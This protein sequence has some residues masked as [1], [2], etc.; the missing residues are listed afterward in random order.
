MTSSVLNM[1]VAEN[2]VWLRPNN[3]LERRL[4]ERLAVEPLLS[5]VQSSEVIE[6]ASKYFEK[7]LIESNASGIVMPFDT[8]DTCSLLYQVQE[9]VQFLS[10]YV[11][12][13]KLLKRCVQKVYVAC[14]D[15]LEEE[16]EFYDEEFPSKKSNRCHKLADSL[17]STSSGF[18]DF[19]GFLNLLLLILTITMLGSATGNIVKYGVLISPSQVVNMVLDPHQWPCLKLFFCLGV[20]PTV[21]FIVE[22]VQGSLPEGLTLLI[23][24]V[25]IATS[26]LYPA[27]VVSTEH[28]N[29]VGSS[30]ILAL[31]VIVFLKLWSYVHVMMWCRSQDNDVRNLVYITGRRRRHTLGTI[32]DNGENDDSD[33][34]NGDSNG[35][36][37]NK[38]NEVLLDE[39]DTESL[40][41]RLKSFLY[42]MAAPTLCYELAYPRS[43]RIRKHFLV[44]RVVEVIFII[45][46]VLAAVQQWIQPI[47][48]NSFVPFN[49]LN[50]LAMLERLLI[51][52]AP[53]CFC[54][55]LFFYGFFHSWCNLVGELLKF[56]DRVFYRDWWN[57]ESVTYFWQNWNVPVHKWAV[58]HLYKPLL[59][60][61]CGRG[62]ATGT[63]FILSA[64]FHEYLI[65]IPLNM[66]R[67]Y[68]LAGMLFQVPMALAI[69]NKITGKTANILVWLTIIIGQPGAI[70]MY[71]YD[72]YVLHY[73]TA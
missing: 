54:W 11:L 17:F 65:S 69:D 68:A 29:V 40:N 14:K 64:I 53:N 13:L 16:E 39:T 19:S 47:V 28:P 73:R 5:S 43:S 67:Y 61:G 70:L 8:G 6:R 52:V 72:Y 57:A 31:H 59:R 25:N 45:G 7:N 4:H 22:L 48:Q 1:S 26:V 3:V 71:Y 50:F 56:G 12:L 41:F 55:L 34:A 24:V 2:L 18:K 60:Q 10:I 33:E 46:F 49:E 15:I 27:Y 42:F 36:V 35:M 21:T 62:F 23:H 44:K 32:Y 20:Y 58:R 38:N 9:F 63:V 30:I 37:F 66:Y 51:L